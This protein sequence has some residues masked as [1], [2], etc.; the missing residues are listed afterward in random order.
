MNRKRSYTGNND[1]HYVTFVCHGRRKLLLTPAER[2]IVISVPG[3]LVRRGKLYLSGF[4]IMPD[5]VHA[6]LWF[7]DDNDLPATMK[8]KTW[9]RLSSHYL[10]AH[11]EKYKPEY[12]DYLKVLRNGRELTP[13]WQRRYYDFNI[14][15][16]EKLREK[17]DYMHHNPVRAEL[18]K[19]A[20]DYNWSSALWYCQRKSVG[21]A[22]EPGF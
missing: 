3:G 18:T 17:L 10:K 15:S 6:I 12:L 21:V 22:I 5:H 16:V 7:R 8:T 4:V 11:Y 14:E 1:F 13:F 9:K 20:A 2:Q 19:K